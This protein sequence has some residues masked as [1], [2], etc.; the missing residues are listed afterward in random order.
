MKSDPA[1]PCGTGTPYSGCCG[2]FIEG[3]ATPETA[4]ALMRSRYTAYVL[5]RAD[6]LQA[7]W[8]P[9]TR[10]SDL[11]LDSP[12]T[13]LGL[14]VVSTR[15]GNSTDKQGWVEFIARYKIGGRAHRLHEISRFVR[16]DGFWVYVSGELNPPGS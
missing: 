4:E 3:T 14:K 13:W 11:D 16:R 15:D 9:T 5:G 12:V 7:T 10:K 6:Y 2:S 1:C 8:H